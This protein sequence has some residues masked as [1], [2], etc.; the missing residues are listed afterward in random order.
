MQVRYLYSELLSLKAALMPEV[1][2]TGVPQMVEN[3]DTG[4]NTSGQT[5]PS[6]YIHSLSFNCL[7]KLPRNM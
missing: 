4:D 3:R 5:G 2:N 1:V 6:V 7:R